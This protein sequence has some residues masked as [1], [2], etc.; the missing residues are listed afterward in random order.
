MG[1]PWVA[2]YPSV[3]LRG[4]PGGAGNRQL[5][6][7]PPEPAGCPTL[8]G[9][10]PGRPPVHGLGCNRQLGLL[11]LW[12]FELVFLHPEAPAWEGG[13]ILSSCLPQ[14]PSG[15]HGGDS[16][17]CGQGHRVHGTESCLPTEG[18]QRLCADPVRCVWSQQG[19]GG[20]PA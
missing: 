18:E 13:Q 10:D 9:L 3:W 11:T 5:P 14:L 1:C 17:G 19:H 20:P 2:L 6:S 8:P 15:T 12:S 16:G 7:S 4:A